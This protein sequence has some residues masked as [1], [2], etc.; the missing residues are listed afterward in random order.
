MGAPLAASENL[1]QKM[2]WSDIVADSNCTLVYLICEW[3]K[4]LWV[5]HWLHLRTLARKWQGQ[6]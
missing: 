6:T 5:H 3:D 2:A 1:G 4:E